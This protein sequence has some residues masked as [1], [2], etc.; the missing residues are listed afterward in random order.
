MDDVVADH[1]TRPVWMGEPIPIDVEVLRGFV[2]R[3]KQAN[4]SVV[5]D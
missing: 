4:G 2:A 3:A 5:A 1:E